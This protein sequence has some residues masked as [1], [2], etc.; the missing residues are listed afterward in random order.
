M[1]TSYSI[2]MRSRFRLG[3][4][5][6]LIHVYTHVR[7]M[8]LVT[9]PPQTQHRLGPQRN[10]NL[11][12]SAARMNLIRA[13]HCWFWKVP[14]YMMKFLIVLRATREGCYVSDRAKAKQQRFLV[15]SATSQKWLGQ[16]QY[17]VHDLPE[18]S[19]FNFTCRDSNQISTKSKAKNKFMCH[20]NVLSRVLPRKALLGKFR[21]QSQSKKK[22]GDE[23]KV[24][25]Q[26]W[27]V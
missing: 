17:Q 21:K 16:N 18:Q 1:R 7:R 6:N 15:V 11:L 19:G 23:N 13:N 12:V 22:H 5:S 9:P 3:R 20:T 27:G 26:I 8:A 25:V 2:V 14:R 4:V 24:T 10:F